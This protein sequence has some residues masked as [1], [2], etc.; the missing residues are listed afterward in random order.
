MQYIFGAGTLDIVTKVMAI[1]GGVCTLAIASGG[2]ILAI[3][4]WGRDRTRDLVDEAEDYAALKA[5]VD[6]LEAWRDSEPEEHDAIRADSAS[7]IS[8]LKARVDAIRGKVDTVDAQCE[9]HKALMQERSIEDVKSSVRRI[10]KRCDDIKRDIDALKEK[11][12]AARERADDRFVQATQHDKDL[13][14]QAQALDALQ[15]QVNNLVKLVGDLLKRPPR[16]T[17]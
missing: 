5:R 3:K 2:L 6:A 14:T 7:G 17:D 12:T 1:V 8:A 10:N 13:A 4:R 11:I 9:R 15:Q 16:G